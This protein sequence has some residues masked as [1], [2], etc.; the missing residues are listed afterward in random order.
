MDQTVQLNKLNLLQAEDRV[1]LQQF[2]D[3]VKRQSPV[4]HMSFSADPSAAFIEKLMVWLRRE[5]HPV[6]L[7]TIGLQPTIGAGCIVRTTNKY[8]DF[9]LRQDFLKKRDLLLAKLSAT[10]A[11][12]LPPMPA[13]EAM[14]TVPPV[15]ARTAR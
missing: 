3:A 9:S 6:L 8:F 12:T 15:A 10:P 2:L 13:P 11:S 14:T 5:I 7:L 1:A 4:I